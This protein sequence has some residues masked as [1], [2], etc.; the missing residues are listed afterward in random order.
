[1]FGLKFPR[2]LI[3]YII[4]GLQLGLIYSI[5]YRNIYGMDILPRQF[6]QFA[7]IAALIGTMEEL[8]FRGFIQGHA[9]K[10]N[11][12]F[13]VLFATF[14][15]TAYK[16]CLFLIPINNFEI[17]IAYL[18]LFTFTGG[19]LFGLLK[20]ISKSVIPAVVAHVVFDILVYGECLQSPW[21]VW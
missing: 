20:E 2:R 10:I 7:L 12:V 13:G 8:T 1:M 11:A 18:F 14:S 9:G 3:L 21:W 6:Y 17:N 4:I 16:C 5:I 15:H 19:L